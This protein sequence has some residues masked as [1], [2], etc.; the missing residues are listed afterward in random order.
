MDMIK[1]LPHRAAQVEELNIFADCLEGTF[2]K[3]TLLNTFPNVRIL[4]VD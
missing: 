2:N 4:Q 3:R 1:Q